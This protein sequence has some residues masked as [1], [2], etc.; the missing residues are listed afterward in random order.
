MNA[1]TRIRH[2]FQ[3]IR[4]KLTLPY[5]ILALLIALGGGVV[6]TQVVLNS[7]EERFTNQLIETRKLASELMVRQEN[8]LLGTLRLLSH[9]EGISEDV[10]LRDQNKIVELAYPITFNA[11]ED[12]V[13]IL[14]RQGKVI[15]SIIRSEDTGKYDFPSITDDLSS[16]PFVAKVI[17]QQADA[18]G[19][20]YSGVLYAGWGNYFF[21]SGPVKTQEGQLVGIILVGKSLTDFVQKIREATLS[22]A[23]IYDVGFHVVSTTFIDTPSAPP[24]DPGTVFADE[25]SQSL[26]RDLDVSSID[27][28]ELLSSWK[29]RGGEDIG[30]LG[31]ALPKAF[32]VRASRITRFNVTTIM[33]LAIL[34]AMFLGIYLSGLITKPILKLKQAASEV[35]NGNLSVQLDIRGGDEVAVLTQSFN[36]MVSNLR[37]SEENLVAAYDR[38]IEGWAKALELR[39]Q[40]TMG[41][42]ARVADLTLEL[43]RA[44]NIDERQMDD[45]RRGALLHDIGK[46]GIPD[47]ILLKPATLTEN[48]W[49]VM[50]RH[51]IFAREMLKQI[52][53]LHPAMEIPSFHHE[54]WDGTGYPNGLVGKE[55][56]M[57]ARIFA[58][59]DVWDALTSDRPYRKAWSHQEALRYI[60]ENS[61][62]H[63]DPQVVK[64]FLDNLREK[65]RGEKKF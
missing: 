27:Y 26:M 25:N 3:S 11:E 33:V 35:S 48:E 42:S 61:G 15:T 7:L 47:N 20:K 30:I 59:I 31:T 44:M 12:A 21:V 36:T 14:D 34:L 8:E 24:V 49:R 6:V 55:I 1:M 63:F 39:N 18:V 28:T 5:I 45:I 16:L 60:L 57:A 40:E 50:R 64:A 9:T 58:V 38:T 13:L 32:L 53:F 41:H 56:P 37:Q 4:T 17:N 51:P 43:A 65:Q 46:M 22:Q 54:K 52:E 62:K 29:A 2:P 23:T 10:S 19:D